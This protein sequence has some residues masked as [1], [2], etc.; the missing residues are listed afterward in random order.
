M[1]LE[2]SEQIFEKYKNIEFHEHPSSGNRV[3]LCRQTDTTTLIL[4]LRNS[5]TVPKNC[6]NAPISYQSLSWHK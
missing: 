1:K 5:D 3:V 2:F 4:D 6:R